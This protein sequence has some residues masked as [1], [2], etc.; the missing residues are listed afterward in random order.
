L[1]DLTPAKDKFKSKRSKS[2]KKAMKRNGS[3]GTPSVKKEQ[4]L[5][6]EKASNNKKS[7]FKNKSAA[8]NR[9]DDD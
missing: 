7:P 5:T 4:S 2:S 3:L 8:L 1:N 9:K 6:P